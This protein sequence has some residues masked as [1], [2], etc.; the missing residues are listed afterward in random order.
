METTQSSEPAILYTRI[1]RDGMTWAEIVLNRPDKGNA[2]T[3][4]M[5]ERLAELA[6]EVGRD[7]SVRALVLRGRGRFFCTGGDIAAWGAFSP[8]RWPAIGYCRASR[9]S[10][11]WRRCLFQ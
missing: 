3:L 5:I 6:E 9:H 11:A 7:R 10:N 4:P 1:E 8:P 2:L